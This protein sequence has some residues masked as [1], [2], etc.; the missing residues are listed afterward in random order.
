MLANL[1]KFEVLYD[2]NYKVGNK[3]LIMVFKDIICVE[4]TLILPQLATNENSEI[5]VNIKKKL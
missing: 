1:L 3:G 5:V 4:Q 2:T